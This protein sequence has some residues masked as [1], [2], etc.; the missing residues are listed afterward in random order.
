MA[1]SVNRA[2]YSLDNS[3][4]LRSPCKCGLEHEFYLDGL[5]PSRGNCGDLVEKGRL[6]DDQRRP[7]RNELS[8]E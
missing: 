1:L 3:D 6:D 4:V 7:A 8:P 2:A 5:S